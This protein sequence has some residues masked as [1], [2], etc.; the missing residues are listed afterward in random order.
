MGTLRLGLGKPSVHCPVLCSSVVGIDNFYPHAN[1]SNPPPPPH[2]SATTFPLSPD[3]GW[4]VGLRW[5]RGVTSGRSILSRDVVED[6]VV[7][8]HSGQCVR[9]T[10][11]PAD[12]PN[13]VLV[14]SVSQ[15]GQEEQS[16]LIKW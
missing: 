14:P 16:H 1:P 7:P 4:V 12:T 8:A 6:L 9:T 2:T 11:G 13:K 3:P 5:G 10:R 15:P